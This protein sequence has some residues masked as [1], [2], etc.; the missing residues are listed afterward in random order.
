MLNV[1]T[2]S[3]FLSGCQEPWVISGNPGWPLT[4]SYFGFWIKGR[5]E[6]FTSSVCA[7]GLREGPCPCP[8]EFAADV[9]SLEPSR[10]GLW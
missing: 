1:G 10:N 4:L 3:C 5:R 7:V 9:V 8:Q 6:V 2:S